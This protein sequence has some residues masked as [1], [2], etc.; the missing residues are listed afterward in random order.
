MGRM[1]KIDRY[2]IQLD[3]LL[4]C[5]QEELDQ[6]QYQSCETILQ[7]ALIVSQNEFGRKHLNTARVLNSL[8]IVYKYLGR[9]VD[10][11][12]S[13]QESF[14][15]AKTELR[16]NDPF[17]ASLH[18]NLGGLE[19]SERHFALAE[20]YG[21]EAVKIRKKSKPK[22]HPDVAEDVAALAAILRERG[23]YHQAKRLFLKV[24]PIFR[25]H[26]TKKPRY[27]YDVAI[28]TNNLAATYADLGFLREAD[29]T[30]RQAL[31][32]KERILPDDHPDIAVTLNNLAMLC[33]KQN[34]YSDAE[35]FQQ[36]CLRILS[37]SIGEKHPKFIAATRNY[38][39]IQDI[40]RTAKTNLNSHG[41]K[42]YEKSLRST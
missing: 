36:K 10:A 37:K 6:G 27:H 31:L 19:H 28:N 29:K 15:I 9:Y 25:R 33:M 2:T 26:A 4:S 7:E 40:A 20:I 18:H 14:D 21:R 42:L 34:A 24:L 32:I 8:G 13:Y 35:Q 16:S 22:D 5:A 1:D 30:Y 11:R 38:E 23:K 41:P 39:K 17:I 3:E 12:K